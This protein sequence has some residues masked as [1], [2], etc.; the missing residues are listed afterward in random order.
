M[1]PEGIPNINGYPEAP[2]AKLPCG[3]VEGLVETYRAAQKARQEAQ[4]AA[5]GPGGPGEG[6]MPME[7]PPLPTTMP[8]AYLQELQA[9]VRS[10]S[11]GFSVKSDTVYGGSAANGKIKDA[12]IQS[13]GQNENVVYAADGC[14]IEVEGALLDK[15]SGAYQKPANLQGPGMSNGLNSVV[16]ASGEGSEVRL[17]GCGIFA[18]CTAGD[19]ALDAAHAVFTVFKGNAQIDDCIL[20]SDASFGHGVYNTSFGTITVNDSY[21]TTSGN[22]GSVVATDNPGADIFGQNDFALSFG[23]ASAGIYCDGGSHVVMQ[24][25]YFEAVNDD[26][27][28]ICND[29]EIR[30]DDC[31]VKG[32]NGLRIRFRVANKAHFYAKDTTIIA[33]RGS[34]VI[35]DGGYGDIELDHCNLIAPN[36]QLVIAVCTGEERPNDIGETTITLRNCRILGSISAAMG[37][38]LHLVLDNTV[39]VGKVDGCG[40]TFENGSKIINTDDAGLNYLKGGEAVK[41]GMRAA[42]RN[43]SAPGGWVTVSFGAEESDVGGDNPM[44]IGGHFMSRGH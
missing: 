16:L 21:L 38:V 31:V 26:G 28:I 10:D 5:G 13:L 40:I 44:P 9:V 36:D 41:Y 20:R 14:K 30:L 15:I 34:A 25:S 42:G 29:G 4:A 37:S 27:A 18:N 17:S 6:G 1:K 8:E 24:R 23:P 2:E 12:Y 3:P 7:M 33:T 39:I 32:E 22:N 19:K 11:S 43:P 35:V